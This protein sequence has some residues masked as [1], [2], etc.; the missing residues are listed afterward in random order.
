MSANSPDQPIDEGGLRAPAEYGDLRKLWWWFDFVIL[1]KLARL[2][3]VGILIVI[4]LM[5]VYWDTLAAYFDKWS[6]PSATEQAAGP[7]AEFFCP[8][9]P[10]V[11]RENPKDK[12][13]ICFMPLSKRK[14]GDA[15]VEALPP[16][17]A[18][19]VQLSPYRIVLA[20]IR[21]WTVAYVPL[22][23]RIT[24]VGYV[25]FSER[26]QKQVAARVKGRIDNLAVNET[27]RMVRAGDVLASV[28]SPDLVV[29]AQNLL[30][31]KRNNN[32]DLL[33]IAQ[34]RL[35]LWD[36]SEDQINDIL[37]EGK[38]N[39][40]LKIR[41]PIDGHV[42]KKYVKEGQYVEEGMPLYDLA[43]L[44]KVWI[45][46]QVYEDDL[47]FLPPQEMFHKSTPDPH[48]MPTVTAT[49]RAYPNDRFQGKLTFVFPHVDQD[50]R[51]VTV[52]FEL[53]NPGHKLR[54]GTTAS[55]DLDVPPR[56]FPFLRAAEPAGMLEKGLV[57]AVPEAAV[58]DTGTQQLV[59]REA[60]AGEF[61]AVKV[62]LG[63]RMT[64]P[65]NVAFFPVLQGLAAGDNVVTAGS[66]L[67]DAETRLNP[68]AGSIYFGG[69]GLNK[70]G[71]AAS[72]VRPSTP[73]DEDSDIKTNIAKLPTE[74][75]RRQALAQQ[76]C[77]VQPESR[78]GSMGPPVK[79]TVNGQ[80]VFLCCKGCE[81]DALANPKDTLATVEKLKRKG[82]PAK[83]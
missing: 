70:P 67:I 26:L 72:P 30:D 18:A 9:H 78:L 20:G 1:V 45:Q 16:G 62:E 79:V 65:E 38:A 33:R 12:C 39:T 57:L 76:F 24:T 64:G 42:I 21:T 8:M 17:I 3:F 2:R 59:Y 61:D 10:T 82:S 58:I 19:R 68:A 81:K 44:S 6:R 54:P 14:K 50:T 48:A 69:S 60:A 43:D 63:P 5:I 80:P 74:S 77:P 28:Y 83:Q 51:T 55:V 32:A 34:D 4:G 52:R 49:T 46:A 22:T 53:D 73:K 35:R 31:A 75:D 56:Q 36:I 47:A 13:P 7:T 29:T 37:S 66:F 25:E 11:V 41:S 15:S 23:K 27:G 40:H 71:P